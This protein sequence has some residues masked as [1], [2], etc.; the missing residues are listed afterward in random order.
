MAAPSPAPSATQEVQSLPLNIAGGN[1]FGRYPKISVE[2]TFNM[3]VSDGFLVDYAGYTN[4]LTL[5]SP[6][7][8]R[9]IF[10]SSTGN[11]MICVWGFDVYRINSTLLYQYVG[12]LNTSA[13]DVFMAE[14]NNKEVVITDGVNMYVYNWGTNTFLIS[15]LVKPAPT[16]GF[17]VL[18]T[19]PGYVSFQ[20]GRIIVVDLG[21]T[22]WYLSNL[23]DATA[24]P[25]GG[26]NDLYIGAIQTKPDTIQACVP[27]PGG[28]NNLLVIGHNVIEEWTD[29]GI[30]A[31]PY[32]RAT[33]FN[34]DYGCLN[35]SSIAALDEKVLW[36]GANEQGGATLMEYDS[37]SHKVQSIT[38]DGMDFV[39]A[40]I[41]NPTNC[42]GFL[43]RQDGHLLYQFTFPADNISYVRDLDTNLFFTVTDE[44]LNYH[45]AR[46]VVF[47]GN[48]FYFVSLNGPNLFE[49]GTQYTNFNYGAGNISEIPRIR[50]CSPIRLPSQRMFIIKSVGFTVENGQP[51]DGSQVI[52]LMISRD[53]GQTFGNSWRMPMNPTGYAKSR[54]IWQRCGQANDASVQLQFW[55]F[56]RFVATQGEVEVYI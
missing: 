53:G 41:T 5:G 29:N 8:G 45:I 25:G 1:K 47:F 21:T 16:G 43:F 24:W 30:V 4:V 28:G 23:N 2:E 27:V 34:V 39:L 14:N 10:R 46:N 48:D 56:Q 54:M 17:T 50:I 19:H 12:T 6:A 7:P 22:N 44:N 51:N 36:L 33:T 32:Q 9:G 37:R 3:L 31:F 35:A 52:D 26:G 40:N 55:G 38:T 49:F 18:F 42:T 15:T 20:D 13:G 11:F